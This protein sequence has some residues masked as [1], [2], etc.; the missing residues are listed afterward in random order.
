MS[1]RWRVA[2][3]SGALCPYDPHPPVLL[4]HRFYAVLIPFPDLPALLI[5][6]CY[7][8]FLDIQFAHRAESR[9][10]DVARY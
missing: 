6:A 7:L 5:I 1:G 3:S 9:A 10:A 8:N 2:T 4:Q